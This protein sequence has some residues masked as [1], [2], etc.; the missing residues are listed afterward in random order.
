MVRES[1]EW[2]RL[3]RG[4]SEERD[5]L[6]GSVAPISPHRCAKLRAALAREF[7]V[8]AALREAGVRRDRLLRAPARRI[9]FPVVSTLRRSLTTSRPSWMKLVKHPSLIAAC[10]VVGLGIVVLEK[11]SLSP[12]V[13]MANRATARA[14]SIDLEVS[15]EAT[16]R[17]P[18]G[19]R[20][21]AAEIASMRSS[22][23]AA[24][25]LSLNEEAPTSLRLD[26]P[27]Q[28][29]LDHNGLAGTP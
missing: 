1:E 26:L 27:V 5:E 2:N 29:L 21:S 24:N 8:D 4:I 9:P 12:S 20:I 7:P 22:F 17:H 13:R 15:P 19:L 16:P 28:A 23:L 25:R 14:E 3:L 6:L 10:L 18:F 11:W